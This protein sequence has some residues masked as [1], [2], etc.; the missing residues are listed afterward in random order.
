MKLAQNSG[1]VSVSFSAV[2]WGGISANYG[3][4]VVEQSKYKE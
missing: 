4:L 2:V 3:G 1:Y